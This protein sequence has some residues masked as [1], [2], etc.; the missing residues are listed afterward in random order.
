[1]GISGAKDRRLAHRRQLWLVLV[2]P[3]MQCREGKER[4]RI[5]REVLRQELQVGHCLIKETR[6]L[7]RLG[8][9]HKR[10][11]HLVALQLEGLGCS[12][13]RRGQ[14]RRV[15][16][17]RV[18]MLLEE[19]ILL[20]AREQHLLHRRR[21]GGCRRPRRRWR[22]LR[23]AGDGSVEVRDGMLVQVEAAEQLSALH[24]RAH[25]DEVRKS[26]K[27][28]LA[29]GRLGRGDQELR[30]VPHGRYHSLALVAGER[31]EPVQ[32]RLHVT[33]GL[34]V[35]LGSRQGL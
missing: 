13:V 12:A 9:R 19:R 29:L 24:P 23:R 10:V 16:A 18:G 28:R 4:V 25:A 11:R 30:I 6:G 22:Q 32:G 1:M 33:A 17:D 14:E 8:A 20:C 26:L 2:E 27:L 34:R 21:L 5:I 15:V 35:V 7:A 31:T 3:L